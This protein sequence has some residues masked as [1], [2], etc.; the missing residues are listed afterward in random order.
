MWKIPE[1]SLALIG[2]LIGQVPS[3]SGSAHPPVVRSVERASGASTSALTTEAAELLDD[4]ASPDGA[5]GSGLV[6][7][8][9]M[10]GMMAGSVTAGGVVT[11][12]VLAG[13]VV[14]GGVVTGGV[15]AGGVVT[16]GVAG[17]PDDVDDVEVG[18]AVGVDATVVSGGHS[19]G[20]GADTSAVSRRQVH[21]APPAAAMSTIQIDRR[22]VVVSHAI[23]A[24][25]VRSGVCG[26]TFECGQDRPE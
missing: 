14:T 20:A 7:G 18:V 23:A 4:A 10:T 3:P 5:L 8:G 17:G 1:L 19:A 13:G 11:G 25:V 9:T 15:L 24:T 6:S 22:T 21:T 2:W 26:L 12:G 16:G